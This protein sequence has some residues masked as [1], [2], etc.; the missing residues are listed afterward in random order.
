ARADS[1]VIQPPVAAPAPDGV[2]LF[3]WG[4]GAIFPS[5]VIA[6]FKITSGLCVRMYL[7]KASFK[8]RAC[9]SNIPVTTSMPA[10]R[11]RSNP[12]PLTC[13]LGSDMHATTLRTPAAMSASAQGP[14]RPWWEHGSRLMY[15]VDPLALLP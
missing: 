3:G 2:V 11:S 7:A 5:S 9:S 14:V 4:G 10:R 1:L 12:F 15:R 6:D 13:G 8:A